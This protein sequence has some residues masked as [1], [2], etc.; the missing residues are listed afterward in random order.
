MNSHS[1]RAEPAETGSLSRIDDG[2]HR[3]FVD[4]LVAARASIRSNGSATVGLAGEAIDRLT[5]IEL[6]MQALMAR[7]NDPAR[8]RGRWRI[9]V[10]WSDQSSDPRRLGPPSIFWTE[11][12]VDKSAAPRSIGR[13]GKREAQRRYVADLMEVQLECA[14]HIEA[15]EQLRQELRDAL[16]RVID[17]AEKAVGAVGPL[18]HPVV[19]IAEERIPGRDLY[20]ERR[21]V[22]IYVQSLLSGLLFQLLRVEATLDVEMP[23][24]NALTPRPN[25]IRNGA[26][27]C[28]W[29][30]R[31]DSGF[32]FNG[33]FF[34][35]T[36]YGAKRTLLR[37]AAPSGNFITREL[38]RKVHL[39][40]RQDALMQSAAAISALRVS[41][42]IIRDTLQRANRAL[43]K[44]LKETF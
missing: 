20:D 32:G 8:S 42:Q 34:Y 4:R 43:T 12:P 1:D 36:R 21:E 17:S 22:K 38:L 15:L 28:L 27:L 18:E 14:G 39:T 19:A 44:V 16:I 26:L 2:K 10:R 6:E 33:P 5:A 13:P 40:Q 29:D 37:V 31:R 25:G 7:H 9:A 3:L 35:T 23:S 41:R 11:Y 30:A 24:F